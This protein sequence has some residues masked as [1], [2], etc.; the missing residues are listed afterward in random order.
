MNQ[1]PRLMGLSQMRDIFASHFAEIREN[2][3]FD[4]QLGMVHGDPR[5]FHLVMQQTPPFVINDHRFG[6]ITRGEANV[7]FNL[8]DRRIAAGTRPSTVRCATSN[9]LLPTRI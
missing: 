2:I 7:N 4:N 6:I 5:V 3:H 9:Y 1:Q 8:Q